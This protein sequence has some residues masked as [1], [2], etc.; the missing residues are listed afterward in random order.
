MCLETAVGGGK[1]PSV[2]PTAVQQNS[3]DAFDAHGHRGDDNQNS[4]RIN[5]DGNKMGAIGI[6][7][8]AEDYLDCPDYEQE[9]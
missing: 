4:S 8:R 6:P 2:I 9:T 3:I 1:E 7:R 5:P